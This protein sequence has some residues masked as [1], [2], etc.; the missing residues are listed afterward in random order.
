MTALFFLVAWL[1]TRRSDGGALRQ[2]ATPADPLSSGHP[3][4]TTVSA[5]HA[6]CAE[7]T[8]P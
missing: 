6:H 2:T 1:R 7:R 4:S 8:Q 3:V 5:T